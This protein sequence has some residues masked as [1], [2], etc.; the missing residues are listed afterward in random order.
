[1]VEVA[2][3]LIWSRHPI[4]LM[5]LNDQLSLP[6]FER[7]PEV[8]LSVSFACSQNDSFIYLALALYQLMRNSVVIYLLCEKATDEKNH[9]VLCNFTSKTFAVGYYYVHYL[10]ADNPVC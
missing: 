8:S 4:R 7:E 9:P 1:M 10:W 6:D 3:E 5:M 2:A